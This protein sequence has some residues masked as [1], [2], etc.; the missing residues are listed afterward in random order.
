MKQCVVA[1]SSTVNTGYRKRSKHDDC[2]SRP[3]PLEDESGNKTRKKRSK[4]GKKSAGRKWFPTKCSATCNAIA[5]H[6]KRP[7]A[8]SASPPL[9]CKDTPHA[10]PDLNVIDILL[11]LFLGAGVAGAAQCRAFMPG[12][13][14]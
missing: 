13:E 5:R 10:P 1:S 9:S 14:A 7:Y 8:S 12:V 11:I 4:K 2:V 3:P 6:L